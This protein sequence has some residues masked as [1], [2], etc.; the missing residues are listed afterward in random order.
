MYRHRRCLVKD[1]TIGLCNDFRTY[2]LKIR[3]KQSGKIISRNS[4]AGYWST[5]RALLKLA[6]TRNPPLAGVLL[7][8]F[9]RFFAKR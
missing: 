1:V 3:V 2:I 5:F 4:A 6:P 7:P 8:V 9:C